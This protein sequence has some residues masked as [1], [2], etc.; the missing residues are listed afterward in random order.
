MKKKINKSCALL[1]AISFLFLARAEGEEVLIKLKVVTEQANIRL[2]PSI[3]SIIIKQVPQGTTLE[4]TGKEGEWYLIKLK[5]DEEDRVS[6]YVHE[7]M[8]IVLEGPPI[9]KEKKEI[10]EE[11]E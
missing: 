8:V 7:S 2:K 6:G 3:G 9:E 4:S 11:L 1:L 10:R 5:P